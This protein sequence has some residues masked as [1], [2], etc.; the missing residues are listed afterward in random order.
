LGRDGPFNCRDHTAWF[1]TDTGYLSRKKETMELYNLSE[2]ISLVGVHVT[3]FPDGIKEAFEGLMKDFG[4]ERDY[5][6]ISWFGE[7]DEIEYFAM[8]RP[9]PAAEA[10]RED[11]VTLIIPEGDYMAETV[12]DWMSN[13]DC[14]KNVFHKMIPDRRPSLND[15]CVEWYKSDKEMVCM[16]RAV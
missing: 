12:H 9:A 15:P 7:G 13:T 10:K 5:Y 6:G 11:L 2:D 8:T 1:F 16:V 4:A 14:I 3:T